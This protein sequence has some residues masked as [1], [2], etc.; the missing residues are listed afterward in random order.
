MFYILNTKLFW[1]TSKTHGVVVDVK[2]FAWIF[3]TPNMTILFINNSPVVK[4][5]SSEKKLFL[6]K[7]FSLNRYLYKIIDHLEY[8]AVLYEA[9]LIIKKS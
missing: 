1:S 5:A 2:V 6:E 9:S 3:L 7:H 8:V 4:F